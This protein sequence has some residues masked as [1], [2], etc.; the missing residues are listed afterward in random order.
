[1][2]CARYLGSKFPLNNRP[3]A[4][5]TFSCIDPTA[6]GNEWMVR[7]VKENGTQNC[8][9]GRAGGG[10]QEEAVAPPP[11]GKLKKCFHYMC[12]LFT[13]FLELQA[14]CVTIFLFGHS[15]NYLAIL[16]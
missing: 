10:G 4:W 16:T 5:R 7:Q 8:C 13:N 2:N 6:R 14:N 3:R 9:H 1:M 12:G 11:P 15:I